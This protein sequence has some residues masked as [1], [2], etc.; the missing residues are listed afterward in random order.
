MKKED[1]DDLILRFDAPMGVEKYTTGSGFVKAKATVGRVGVLKYLLPDGSIRREL[2]HPDEVFNPDSLETLKQVPVTL[3]HPSDQGLVTPANSKSVTVGNAGENPVRNDSFLEMNLLVTDAE[4]ISALE[5]G[6]NQISPGYYTRLDFKSGSYN[7]EQYDAIQ[8]N[9]RYNH[10]AI[11]Q[12]GRAGPDV[13]LHLDS[14]A[15]GVSEQP[16]QEKTMEENPQA[17]PA[18]VE[19][20]QDSIEVKL[21]Q[22]ELDQ[23]NAQIDVLKQQ[24]ET[25][26]GLRADAEDSSTI[27]KAV[28]ARLG[29]ERQAGGVLGE[30]VKL[31]G[32]SDREVK[33]KAVVAVYPALAEK[34]SK[35]TDEQLDTAFDLCLVAEVKTD[36]EEEQSFNAD[37]VATKKAEDPFDAFAAKQYSMGNKGDK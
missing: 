31:D 10:L 15:V 26:K 21:L 37:E 36:A 5:S 16:K 25:E 12:H 24:L 14:A 1:E 32:L 23:A 8:R 29:L 34:A 7:G 6:T 18:K 27:Q 13:R 20:K 2:R 11:V 3:G 19:V 35:Y 17:T 30:G 4:A 28:Q 9:I 33:E 22:K